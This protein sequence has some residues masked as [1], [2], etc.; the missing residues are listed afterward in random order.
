MSGPGDD[1]GCGAEL[2]LQ[3]AGTGSQYMHTPDSLMPRAGDCDAQ[4]LVI[5]SKATATIDWLSSTEPLKFEAVNTLSRQVTQW[6]RKDCKNRWVDVTD[7]QIRFQCSKVAIDQ[8][9]AGNH[10]LQCK[11]DVTRNPKYGT[12]QIR[13]TPRD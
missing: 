11:S 10:R 1:K 12:L 5:P 2:H 9:T 3:Q 4:A 8:I 13:A 7:V 6:L